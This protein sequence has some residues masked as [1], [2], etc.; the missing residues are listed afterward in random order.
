MKASSLSPGNGHGLA[1]WRWADLVVLLVVGSI[2]AVLRSHEL[3]RPGIWFDESSSCRWIQFPMLELFQRTAADCHPPFYWV[4]LK[5]WAALFGDTIGSLRF[6]S[7]VFGVAT[8]CA[9]YGLVRDLPLLTD[10]GN[11]TVGSDRFAAILASL[12]V[13]TSP[14]HI[15]WSQEMRMYSLGTFFAVT[16]TWLLALALRS[17]RS[18]MATWCGYWLIGIL[19]LYTLYFSLF[20]LLAHGVFVTTRCVLCGKWSGRYF[21]TV[22]AILLAW[23]PWIP[24]LWSMYGTVQV[25]FPQGPLTW[26]EFRDVFWSMFVQQ[27]FPVSDNLAKIALIE[28]CAS[29]VVMLILSGSPDR[30]LV[31]LCAFVPFYA[32]SNVSF[33][34]QNLV[35]RHRLILGQ[36][37]LLIC[38]AMFVRRFRPSWLR[39]SV[40]TISVLSSCWMTTYYFAY[41]DSKAALPGLRAAM[42]FIDRTRSNDEPAVFVNPML[43]LNGL[44]YASD[45]RNIFAMG[46]R[47][48]YPYFQGSS[49]TRDADHLKLTDIPTTTAVVWVIDADNWMGSS[50]HV[51]MPREWHLV[52]EDR[53]PEFYCEIVVKLYRRN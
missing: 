16:S 30:V 5:A 52:T 34:S 10:E 18:G 13:A 17:D 14:F 22:L 50:W 20:T 7:G 51:P 2:A 44:V 29:V 1:R 41:R 42:N 40:A 36:V 28:I 21:V 11:S 9:V 43:Y 4:L 3:D 39:W 32:I 46:Q 37:F 6:M 23:L 48:D 33:L 27:G 25:S 24:S 8:V 38:W 12:L 15:E 31:A 35:A 26:L 45:S 53:F 49:L 19:S 47:N